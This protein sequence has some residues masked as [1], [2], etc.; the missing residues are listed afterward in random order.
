MN[1]S[2]CL[3]SI[4]VIFEEAAEILE[5]HILPCLT[6][7]TEQVILIGDH[8]QL[9]PYISYIKG[10]KSSS[11]SHSLFERLIRSNFHVNVLNIQYRMRNTFAELLCPLIYQKLMSHDSVYNFPSVRNMRLNL[12]F[13]Q[14]QEPETQILDG[15]LCNEF[16]TKKVAEIVHHL[17]EVSGYKNKE[18]V[19]LT[20]YTMQVESIKKKVCQAKYI[21]GRYRKHFCLF[22]YQRT[23][24]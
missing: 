4:S 6:P 9:K 10:L 3:Y 19:V 24:I 14:H 20:P 7:Y 17:V 21:T 11:Q 2:R 23:Q 1:Q 13:L 15:F 22:S 16:E 12:Y 5:A 18:V 8:M